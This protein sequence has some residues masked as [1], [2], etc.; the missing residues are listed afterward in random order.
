MGKGRGRKPEKREVDGFVELTRRRRHEP[1]E[2]RLARRT[3]GARV[4]ITTGKGHMITSGKITWNCL[5]PQEE[6]S[7]RS[8]KKSYS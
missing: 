6:T 5:A 3:C 8:E 2:N 4:K 1:K 7:R